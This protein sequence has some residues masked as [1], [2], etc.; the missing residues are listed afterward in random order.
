MNKVIF[1]QVIASLQMYLLYSEVA[2]DMMEPFFHS[3]DADS[4]PYM[5]FDIAD[6][7]NRH[8]T[9]CSL[10]VEVLFIGQRVKFKLELKTILHGLFKKYLL[11]FKMCFCLTFH[12]RFS[13]INLV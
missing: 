13:I 3:Q 11:I 6:H 8:C 2:L 12:L 10:H 9:M 1:V 7:L 4:S 5:L